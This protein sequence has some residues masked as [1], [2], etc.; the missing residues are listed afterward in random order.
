MGSFARKSAPLQ[1]VP[2]AVALLQRTAHCTQRHQVL[3]HNLTH[4]PQ[5]TSCVFKNSVWNQFLFEGRKDDSLRG[6]DDSH[7]YRVGLNLHV[8]VEI[9]WDAGH[10][11]Y[12]GSFRKLA[13]SWH[14]AVVPTY[15]AQFIS[16]YLVFSYTENWKT[17]RA[18][19]W[20]TVLTSIP[21]ATCSHLRPIAAT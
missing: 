14:D 8:N 2:P 1:C 7:L 5:M 10:N 18:C 4:E 16:I 19:I 13:N 21:A 17:P 12:L 9:F 20:G 11:F 15:F 3:R 6:F